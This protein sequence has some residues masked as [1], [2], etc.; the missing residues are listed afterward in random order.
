MMSPTNSPLTV[1][2]V[3]PTSTSAQTSV[4][5]PRVDVAGTSTLLLVDQVRTL[6]TDY[7][8]GD[9]VDFLHPDELRE[10]ELALARYLGLINLAS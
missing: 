6:D 9:P 1:V 10:A 4:F 3:I 8:H 7:V 5:R 2:T